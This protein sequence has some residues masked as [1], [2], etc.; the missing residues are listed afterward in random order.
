MEKNVLF[1]EKRIMRYHPPKEI[2]N[3]Q[4]PMLSADLAYEAHGKC[5]CQTII[6]SDLG[7]ESTTV[8]EASAP[9]G[10]PSITGC[11]DYTNVYKIVALSNVKFRSLVINNIAQTQISSIVFGTG[12]FK[13]MTGS[14]IYADFTAID[15]LSGTLICYRDCQQS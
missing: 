10:Q 1:V 7:E 6:L 4:A 14:E 8:W 9:E 2:S 15:I 5:G 3:N 13:L 11:T 12:S